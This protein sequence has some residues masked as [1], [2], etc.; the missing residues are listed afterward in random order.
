MN[1]G[2]VK[3]HRKMLDNRMLKYDHTATVVFIA[4]L[5]LVRHKDGTYDT[6]RFRLSEITGVNPNT[7][8][9]TLKRL[10]KNGM[11]STQSIKGQYTV[12]TICNWHNYQQPVNTFVNKRSTS[13]QQAVNTKQEVIIKNNIN[14]H[15][16]ITEFDEAFKEFI[17][18]RIKIKKPMTDKAIELIQ[19]K[20]EKMYPEREDMQIKSLY[21]S[22]EN[23]WQGV[24]TVK[25]TNFN[26]AARAYSPAKP[27]ETAV[28]LTDEQRAKAS[29]QIE[30]IRQQLLNRSKQ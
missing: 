17:K 8:Y 12:I 6:G 13:G 14:K 18:M 19:N 16:K 9:S 21:Q 23:S 15:K 27:K 11:I 1:E 5:L 3:L 26:D 2:W 24:F 25:N 29:L 30:K 7:L 20:L 4:L 28:E 22:I 10:E